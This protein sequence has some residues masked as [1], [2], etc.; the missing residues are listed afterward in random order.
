MNSQPSIRSVANFF[1]EVSARSIWQWYSHG[2]DIVLFAVYSLAL[3]LFIGQEQI[4]SRSDLVYWLL[5]VPALLLPVLRLRQTIGNLLIGVGRPFSVLGL[6]AGLWCLI[7]KDY[8]A[9][10]QLF[11][12]V[13]VAGWATRNEV[14]L[15]L[16]LLMVALII[17]YFAGIVKYYAQEDYER[18]EWLMSEYMPSKPA[19]KFSEEEG[20]AHLQPPELPDQELSGLHLNAWGILPGQTAPAYGPWRVSVTPNIASSGIVSVLAIMLSLVWFRP[21]PINVATLAFGLYF[22]ILSFVRSALIALVVMTCG[23]ALLRLVPARWKL[24]RLT[25]VFLLTIG[26]VGALWLAPYVI[27]K[28]QDVELV[29]RLFLREES[30]LSLADIYR[31][32]YR[33]WLWSQHVQIFLSSDYLMGQGS[34]LAKSAER[35]MINY[36]QP[37]SDSIAFPTRMLATYGLPALALVW[38]IGERCIAHARENDIWALSVIPALVWLMMTWGAAFHPTSI[39]YVLALLIIARGSNAFVGVRRNGL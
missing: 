19:A 2:G 33:P 20:S 37:R 9:V 6:V 12:V 5:V 28:I 7:S 18:H 4:V 11:L 29:S 24:V 38:F 32:V 8:S 25:A 3:K 30:G 35:A 14:R 10:L 15:D 39:V 36:G 16:R 31:Q 13:W 21:R 17:F 23:Q 34:E 26:T 22:A 1:S 27:Y